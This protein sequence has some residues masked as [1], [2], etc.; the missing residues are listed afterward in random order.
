MSIESKGPSSLIY[1]KRSNGQYCVA[2]KYLTKKLHFFQSHGKRIKIRFSKK[3]CTLVLATLLYS[4]QTAIS[5]ISHKEITYIHNH[6]QYTSYFTLV[7]LYTDSK[8]KF[9]NYQNPYLIC[10]EDWPDPTQDG[11]GQHRVQAKHAQHHGCQVGVWVA[12]DVT[13][14][15]QKFF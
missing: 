2:S 11:D 4:L 14:S 3:N 5:H 15:D 8:D 12:G 1:G 6:T 13:K 10:W 7:I 9:V